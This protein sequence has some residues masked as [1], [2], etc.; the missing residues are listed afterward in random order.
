MSTRADVVDGYC[1]THSA[2]V[3]V[4]NCTQSFKGVHDIQACAR[5]CQACA[6][7]TTISYS[8]PA[9][10]DDCSLYQACTLSRAKVLRGQRSS[11]QSARTEDALALPLQ[12]P[13]FSCSG[14]DRGAGGTEWPALVVSNSYERYA[15]VAR[16]LARLG[17]LPMR[18]PSTVLAVNN[19]ACPVTP[20]PLTLTHG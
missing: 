6:S 1:G 13:N 10:F 18:V 3:P 12:P 5:R 4:A 20:P 8:P 17:F 7:C 9:I 19:T 11:Y 2:D 14:R 15:R 16:L